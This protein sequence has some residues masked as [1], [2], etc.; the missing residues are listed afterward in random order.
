MKWILCVASTATVLAGCAQFQRSADSGYNSYGETLQYRDEDNGG[1]GHDRQTRQTAYE[2]GKDPNSLSSK[3][4]REIKSRQRVRE[5]ERTLSSKKEREQYSKV[6][7]WF[8]SDEEKIEFLNVPSIEGRQQWINSRNIWNRSQAPASEMKGLVD[9]QDI[10]I[11]MPQDYVKKSWGDP[12][13]VEHSGNPI[14]KNERWKYERFIS[15]AEGYRKEVR[16]V[17]F[18]GGRVVGWETE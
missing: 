7:P 3:D 2:L 17:Y 1:R 13:N 5:M 10:A 9:S 15:T 4:L 18:E 12:L 14:Y 8:K 16:F 11:G 6:L